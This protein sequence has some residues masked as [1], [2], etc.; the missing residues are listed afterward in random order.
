MSSHL[1]D[2]SAY[3]Q[4]RHSHAVDELLRALAADGSLA[5]CEI[6][7]LELLYSARGRA[8]YELRWADLHSLPWLAVTHDVMTRAMS[9]QRSARSAG[10][11]DG[12]CLTSSSRPRRPSTVRPSCT[13][14]RTSISSQ[15]SRGS[16]RAG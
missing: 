7:A 14:T 9:V 8:D 10:S 5:M 15:A 1:A 13:T 6:V 11:T 2:T 3:E 12:R 4:Q 16:R